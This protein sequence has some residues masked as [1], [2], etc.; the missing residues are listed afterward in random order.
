MTRDILDDYIDGKIRGAEIVASVVMTAVIT[1]VI[2]AAG[3]AEQIESAFEWF[4]IIAVVMWLCYCIAG[5][6]HDMY[7]AHRERKY[8]TAYL[9]H[10]KEAS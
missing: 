10:R 7:D 3:L 5:S 9:H 4:V 1:K 6:I 8:S 2:D